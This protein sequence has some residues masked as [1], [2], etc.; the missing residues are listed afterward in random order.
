MIPSQMHDRLV[1]KGATITAKL[2][3]M[4][5]PRGPRPRPSARPT[6]N[7][8]MDFSGAGR[9]TSRDGRRPAEEVSCI[10]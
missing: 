7:F 8:G 6:R 2:S 3:P 1:D 10:C 9:E 4:A 5:V